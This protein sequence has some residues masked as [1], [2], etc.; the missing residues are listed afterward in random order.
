[1][2][3]ALNS[4]SAKPSSARRDKSSPLAAR[5]LARS[6]GICTVTFMAYLI[7]SYQRWVK[8]TR[9]TA[10][11]QRKIPM[12]KLGSGRAGSRNGVK[13][14]TKLLDTKIARRSHRFG[15]ATAR[16]IGWSSMFARQVDYIIREP[17][18]DFV[19]REIRVLD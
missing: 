19:E 9:T 13:P 12:T 18:C 6:S 4:S 7:S 8:T 5:R 2:W 10:A 15:A 16:E 3:P 1:M 14:F 17:E 11:A